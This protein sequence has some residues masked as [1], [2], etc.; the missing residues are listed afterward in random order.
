MVILIDRSTQL[1]Q[2]ADYYPTHFLL[3]SQ[4]K[5]ILLIMMFMSKPC[6]LIVAILLWEANVS[7][8]SGTVPLLLSH[9]G[10]RG[11]D[12]LVSCEERAFTH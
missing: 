11:P 4:L 1:F 10:P 12:A 9:V 2:T 6:T 7:P 3:G 8:G 5:I